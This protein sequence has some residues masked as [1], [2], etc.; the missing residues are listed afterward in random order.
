MPEGCYKLEFY[1]DAHGANPL[2]RWLEKELTPEQRRAVA[3]AFDLILKPRGP[4]VVATEFGK[5]LG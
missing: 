2:L 1:I 4:N 3:A 5:A